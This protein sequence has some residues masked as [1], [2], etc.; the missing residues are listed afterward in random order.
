MV[1]MLIAIV[2][3]QIVLQRE[4]CQPHI[5]GRYRRPLFAQLPVDCCVLMRR[6]VVGEERGNSVAREKLPQDAL[7]FGLTAT[8]SEAGAQLRQDHEGHEYRLSVLDQLDS[9]SNAYEEITVAAPIEH[10]PHRQK[11]SRR[12]APPGPRRARIPSQRARPARQSEQ[13]LRRNHR[14]G[15]YRERSSSPKLGVNAILVG[16]RLLEGTM[17]ASLRLL[18]ARRARFR[19]ALSTAEG[20]PRMVYC[21]HLS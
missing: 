18:P 20:T 19:S 8:K 16:E 11:R 10:D 3:G 7:V 6:L 4:R 21:M 13:R 5:V 12:A 14:S 15:S 9:L 1:E 17:T 2:Q